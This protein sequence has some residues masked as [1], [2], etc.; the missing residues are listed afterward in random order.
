[1]SCTQQQITAAATACAQAIGTAC[2]TAITSVT[3]KGSVSGKPQGPSNASHEDE[4][5]IC[6]RDRREDC[7]V[8]SLSPALPIPNI[9]SILLYA[10][11]EIAA[12]SVPSPEIQP[13]LA[14]CVQ[15][16]AQFRALHLQTLQHL[17]RPSPQPL[18]APLPGQRTASRV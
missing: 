8:C 15:E 9:P 11:Y 7:A 3:A 14:H 5:D 2:A 4:A 16:A 13:I 12:G 18:Q 1:M 6:Q 17:P 10:V